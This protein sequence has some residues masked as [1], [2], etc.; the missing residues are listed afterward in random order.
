[1]AKNWKQEVRERGHVKAGWLGGDQ[2]QD[3]GLGRN[4]DDSVTYESPFM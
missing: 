2:E 1:M 3:A 4:E